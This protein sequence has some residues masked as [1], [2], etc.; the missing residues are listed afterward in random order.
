MAKK[1]KPA[2]EIGTPKD[3]EKDKALELAVQTLTKEFGKGIIMTGAT[4]EFPEIGRFGSGSVGLDKAMN[5]GW[6]RGRIL[7]IY[8]PESSGKTTLAL[9]AIA[10]CQKN[11]GTC[12]F[13]DAEHSLDVHY[14]SALGVDIE[15]LLISQPDSGEDCLN[16]AETLT[17]SGAVDLIVIDSVSA[18]VPKAELEGNIG[19]Q[20]PGRQAAIMSQAMRMLVGPAKKTDTAIIFINQIRYKI[21]VMFGSPETTSGGNALKFYA[22][23]RL[24]IRRIATLSQGEDKYGIRT[25]VKV[26]KNK[27]GPPFKDV[28]FNIIFGK[29]I[30]WATD[31]LDLAES[32]GIIDKAGAWYSYK[33]ERLG[34][35]SSNASKAIATTDGLADELRDRIF[36][37]D[38]VPVKAEV[39]P[40][41]EVPTSN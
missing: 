40:P 32:M 12:A 36:N 20:R 33:G 23:Q 22:S 3:D 38:I 21:G 37:P 1:K 14:A 6:A 17:R 8:G 35:G 41:N 25:R 31:L 15:T 24:D 26:V 18:L 13:I 4:T 5:G 27:V 16:V 29:G 7:E 11:G 39:D 34:Q 30:D 2:K 28:E 10:E 9:H 19:D